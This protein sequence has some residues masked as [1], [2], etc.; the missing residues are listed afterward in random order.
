M[1]SSNYKTCVGVIGE[2]RFNI[3]LCVSMFAVTTKDR[4]DDSGGDD[5]EELF[6]D[7]DEFLVSKDS[8]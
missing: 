5:D 8:F 1:T 4:D 6:K 7:E 2:G 3:S